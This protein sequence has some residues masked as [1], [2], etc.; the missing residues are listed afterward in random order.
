[1]LLFQDPWIAIIH[2]PLTLFVVSEHESHDF[3]AETKDEEKCADPDVFRRE[4]HQ[5][6]A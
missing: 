3:D 5:Y 1:M 2:T 6:S 4:E